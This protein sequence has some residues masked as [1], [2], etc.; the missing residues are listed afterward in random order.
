[1]EYFEYL[2][3]I[4][5]LII[6]PLSNYCLYLAHRNLE[7]LGNSNLKFSHKWTIIWW[8]IPIY[9]L[10]KPY[11]IVK[12]IWK[13]SDPEQPVQSYHLWNSREYNMLILTWFIPYILMWISLVGFVL[14]VFLADETLNMVIELVPQLQVLTNFLATISEIS[15]AWIL[16]Q[17][18]LGQNIRY[19]KMFRR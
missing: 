14:Y 8:Y 11:Q 9:G 13:G 16:V 6:V 19:Q 3:W 4:L 10:W 18:G 12:E 17:I 2:E 5:I 1:M 7:A 15:F